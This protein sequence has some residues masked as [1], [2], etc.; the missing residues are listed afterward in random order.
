LIV[1]CCQPLSQRSKEFTQLTDMMHLLGDCRTSRG[2]NCN[3]E[4]PRREK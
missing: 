1:D 3:Q 4:T 2:H